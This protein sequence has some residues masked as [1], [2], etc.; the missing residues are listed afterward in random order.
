MRNAYLA[1]LH[2][3]A[4]K[5]SQVLAVVADNG[6]IVYDKF[7][8]DFPKQFINFGIAEAT[9]ISVSAGLA[10]CG[11][12]PFA[13]T[14]IPFLTMRAYEQVRN[15]VC[16][17]KQNVKLVGVGAGF[18]YST[19]GPTHHAIEDLAI[20]RVLPNMTILSP[21]SPLEAKKV[22]MAAA[23]IDGPVYIRLGTTKEPEIYETDY[24]FQVGRGVTLLKGNDLTIVGTGSIVY[25]ILQAAQELHQHGIHA[26]VINLHSIKPIDHEI[27]VKASRETG[28][29]ITVEEHSKIGGL[30]GAVAEVL[31]E[32]NGAPQIFVRMGMDDI[33]CHGYGSHDYLKEQN[34]LSTRSIYEK[35]KLLYKQKKEG[36]N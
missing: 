35:V 19:L 25:N 33:F 21:A 2:D 23:K 12:I 28:V 1:A 3:L 32:N 18:A 29:V 16:L 27:L 8:A 15:D 9:M 5:N 14:I 30:G 22:T 17:Q 4:Q 6:A 31:L 10:N 34:S 26:R 7:R 20:M 36:F 13:Y 24:D 11:K